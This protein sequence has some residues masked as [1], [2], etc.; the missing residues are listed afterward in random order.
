[1]KRCSE[2]SVTRE[3]Q[4]KT[5]MR[6]HFTH[7]QSFCYKPLCLKC[8]RSLKINNQRWDNVAV[9]GKITGWQFGLCGRD[10]SAF[11]QL[12]TLLMT[13]W[14]R[15]IR[16]TY[17]KG[18]F[19]ILKHIR[20]EEKEAEEPIMFIEVWNV[21]CGIGNNRS[22][23]HSSVEPVTACFRA[24]VQILVYGNWYLS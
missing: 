18:W 2:L 11:L 15:Q 4:V 16:M 14:S 13:L 3:M 10:V 5:T 9:I 12:V 7:V 17:P 22:R 8:F 21:Y 6:Y 19:L 24:W 20:L 23:A 1:M